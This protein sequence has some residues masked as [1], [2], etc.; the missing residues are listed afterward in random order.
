MTGPVNSSPA[1][2]GNL[3]FVGL[4]DGRLLALDKETG[5]LHWEFQTGDLVYGSPAVHKG[6]VYIGSGDHELYALDALTG[7]VRWSRKTGGRV[8]ALAGGHR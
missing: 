3:V 6:V 4:R 2:A 7:E 5:T 1:I 8:V